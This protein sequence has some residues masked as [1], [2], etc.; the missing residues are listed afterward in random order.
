MKF[1]IALTALLSTF[2][3]ASPMPEEPT[4]SAS[5]C[6]NAYE[7]CKHTSDCC[8]GFVCN[9]TPNGGSKLCEYF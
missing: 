6:A 5:S 3:L 2:A 9:T 8:F 7:E 1:S 4:F